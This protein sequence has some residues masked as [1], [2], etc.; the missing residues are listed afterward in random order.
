MMGILH[1]Y[2]RRKT[3][4]QAAAPL[5]LDNTNYFPA[6]SFAYPCTLR[7][8]LYTIS[9][10]SQYTGLFILN[11][12][13]V[14]VSR[15]DPFLSFGPRIDGHSSNCYTIFDSSL[16]S[17]RLCVDSPQDISSRTRDAKIWPN[18]YRRHTS[19]RRLAT[20]CYCIKFLS[21]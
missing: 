12:Y 7:T 20:F 6:A 18:E 13:L 17:I 21:I 1:R 11:G 3:S 8:P 4:P 19:Q 9:K 2:G 14:G 15:Y 16:R 5:R 10:S